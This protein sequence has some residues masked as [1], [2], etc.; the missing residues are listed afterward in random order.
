MIELREAPDL[1]DFKTL[2]G[3]T[4]LQAVVN[5]AKYSRPRPVILAGGSGYGGKSFMLRASAVE[6]NVYMYSLGHRG[7]KSVFASGTYESLKDRHFDYFE[8]EWGDWGRIV[9]GHRK[10]GRCFLFNNSDLGAICLR[11][12]G[13]VRERRGTEY[14][15]GFIDESTEILS[16]VFGDF[17]YMVRK[18]GMPHL[19][20]VLATNP[21]GVG[22]GWNKAWFRP[23]L[24]PNIEPTG[25]FLPWPT[26]H[27]LQPGQDERGQTVVRVAFPEE[28]KAKFPSTI[29]PSGKEDP[30]DYIYIPFLPTDN[31]QYDEA[32][33]WRMVAHLPPH[34]QQARRWGSWDSP[35][36]AR[37]PYL[38]E[39]DHLFCMGDEFPNGIPHE[40]VRILHCDYGLRAPYCAL[41]TAIDHDGD[42]WTYREDYQAGLT[43]DVQ[44]Q[45]IVD[46]TG[47]DEFVSRGFLDPAMWSRFPHHDPE[48][49]A[50]DERSA[51]SYYDEIIEKDS[52]ERQEVGLAPRFFST[53]EPGYNRNRVVALNTLDMLLRRG[54]PFPDWYI[55]QGCAA[56]W[57]ELTGAV[58]KQGAGFREYSEDIDER[59][60]DHAITAAYYG[61]HHYLSAPEVPRQEKEVTARDILEAQRAEALAHDQREFERFVKRSRR[62]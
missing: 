49:R 6:S 44:A 50:Q 35:E 34:V 48:K 47:A 39:K 17:L 61:L 36:G 55:E 19:A 15:A 52:R 10:Y 40:Y 4:P 33:F 62:R 29:D 5:E 27:V 56:L 43:A 23:W 28:R 13:A 2:A 9:D 38:N 22:H 53:W 25:E 26:G 24:P 14:G 1:V 31:P 21:D 45:R 37:F 59:C 12:L 41:W 51:A 18:P 16:N 46:K 8:Q 30:L 7:S 11:N 60:P 42:M 58:F 3:F 57:G 54:N 32:L 20:V